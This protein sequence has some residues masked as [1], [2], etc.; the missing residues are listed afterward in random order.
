[1]TTFFQSPVPLPEIRIE[2]YYDKNNKK[3][4]KIKRL[5]KRPIEISP[6]FESEMKAAFNLFDKDKSENIDLHELRDA[7][8]ALGV[9]MSKKE[10]Q[11]LMKEYDDDN[12]GTVDF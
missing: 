12:N 5:K 10:A 8:R 7:M 2:F 6:E 4:R 1:M 3:R 9:R 11:A